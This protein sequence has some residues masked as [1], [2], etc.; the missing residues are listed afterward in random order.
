M[1]CAVALLFSICLTPQVSVSHGFVLS[2]GTLGPH[3]IILSSIV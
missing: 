2:E 1:R 3:A